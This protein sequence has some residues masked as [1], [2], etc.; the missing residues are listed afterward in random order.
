M[1]PVP[2][3]R[4]GAGALLLSAL[5]LRFAGAQEYGE[6]CLAKFKGG[7]ED[8]V[9]D[10]DESVKAGATFISSPSLDRYRDCVAACCK[11]PRCN[12]AFMQRADEEG[13]VNSCFLFDCLYKK[14]YACRFVRKKGYTNYIL[15]TLYESYLKLDNPPSKNS[16]CSK[17]HF[18]T[19]PH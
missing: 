15:E 6:E 19:A 9:L 11:E 2:T 10:T 1:V 4:L 18:Q 13:L 5:L 16:N 12:V 7:R 8:F 17:L 3:G 14:K